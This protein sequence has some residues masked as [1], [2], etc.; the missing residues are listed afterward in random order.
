MVRRTQE[1]GMVTAEAAVIAPLL[2][3]LVFAGVWVVSLGTTQAAAHAGAHEAAR[4]IARG[5]PVEVAR[6]AAH[7]AVPDARVDIDEDSGQVTVVVTSRAQA[8][9]FSGVGVEIGARA[10]ARLEVTP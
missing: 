3:T 2:V 8:P 1:H 5:E 9:M 7:D 6:Q 10:T 4:L